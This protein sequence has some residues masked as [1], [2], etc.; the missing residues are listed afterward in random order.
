MPAFACPLD[1]HEPPLPKSSAR[2]LVIMPTA[3]YLLRFNGELLT[4]LVSRG[5]SVTVASPPSA[6]TAELARLGIAF[7]GIP[8]SRAGLNPFEYLHTF[9]TLR[10]LLRTERPQCLF[11]RG[12]KAVVYG[13]LAAAAEHMS[14]VH[15][16]LA[17]LGY[18]FSEYDNSPKRRLIAAVIKSQLRAALR[19]NRSVFVQNPDDALCLRQAG[20]VRPEQLHLVPSGE[21]VNLDHFTPCRNGATNRAF[22]MISRL[23]RTKGVI[24]YVNAARRLHH[25][26]P[27]VECRL[28]GPTW[29]TPDAISQAEIAQ[30]QA[31]G[32]I[33]YLGS[34]ADVRPHLSSAFALAHPSY[35]REGVPTVV[36]EAMAMRKPIV[37]TDSVGCRETIHDGREGLLVPPRSPELLAQAMSNL[38]EDSDLAARLARKARDRAEAVFDR[39]MV[40]N[41]YLRILDL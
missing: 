24:D 13:S 19:F 5:H 18:A 20:L 37:T 10:K 27:E 32:A 34:T 8:M 17:G 39:R 9:S 41:R 4:T 12:I 35:Y 25:R 40:T 26:H 6:E 23:L 16:L 15:S 2:V 11:L 3:D 1:R 38:L 30:W 29:D 14:N 36:L 31:E 21:G 28:L 22:I 33:R 7:R